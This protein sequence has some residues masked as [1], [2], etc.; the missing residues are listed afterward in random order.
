[1]SNNQPPT[2][3]PPGAVPGSRAN[4]PPP[5][6]R[7]PSAFSAGAP[8]NNLLHALPTQGVPAIQRPPFAPRHAPMPAG[9]PA[10]I[11]PAPVYPPIYIDP[12]LIRIKHMTETFHAAA[13][14]DQT[15]YS[16]Y[17]SVCNAQDRH[18]MYPDLVFFLRLE[19]QIGWIDLLERHHRQNEIE[20]DTAQL[21][22]ERKK[23]I[24][25][26]VRKDTTLKRRAAQYLT[27]QLARFAP[28][29]FDPS[30]VRPL[31]KLLDHLYVL[32]DDLFFKPKEIVAPNRQEYR[33]QVVTFLN[34]EGGDAKV[35]KDVNTW[36]MIGWAELQRMLSAMT[37]N[38]QAAQ[39][40]HNY[41]WQTSNYHGN[42][43]YWSTE[44]ENFEGDGHVLSSDAQLAEM[45]RLLEQGQKIYIMHSKQVQIEENLS[46]ADA[47]G[48]E[49]DRPGRSCI[50][51]PPGY[52]AEIMGDYPNKMK[53]SLLSGGMAG[54]GPAP[55]MEHRKG[56]G[57]ALAH[58]HRLCLRKKKQ[59]QQK[60]R[61]FEIRSKN[62]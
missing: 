45:K 54:G 43:M 56:K 14:S 20:G 1:M 3:Y 26:L 27:G 25:W 13:T 17:C 32:E 49:L 35:V 55:L 2:F 46:L 16:L 38:V 5:A 19:L 8:Q 51:L 29:D 18:L 39:F 22:T 9:Y 36:K 34:W 33:I 59:K 12:V 62:D 30:Q 31:A 7:R 40:G 37:Q 61:A 48:L 24:E 57:S 21:I 15:F 41:G 44:N 4:I 53:F 10:Q 60:A 47:L 28:L 52:T 23:L 6:A 58:Q 42:W 11:H 50:P